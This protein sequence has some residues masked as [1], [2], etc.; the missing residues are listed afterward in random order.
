MKINKYLIII[1]LAGITLSACN[2]LDLQPLSEASTETW[3]TDRT[4]VE[5][6]LNTLYLH[7][8]WPM[9]KNDFSTVSNGVRTISNIMSLDEPTDDWMNRSSVVPFIN[10]TLSGSNSTFL[11]NT[12]SFS[13]K[14]IS[15]CNTILANIEKSK[16]N[17]SLELYERYMADARFVRACQ[18]SRLISYFGD[19]VYFTQDLELE[20]GFA[21]G[22]VDK[23]EVLGHIYEDFD[24]AIEKLPVAYESNEVKRGTK[25]AAYGMKARVALFFKDY[26]VARDAAKAC[27]DL[28]AYQLF[29]DFGELFLS[30]TKNSVETVFGIPRSTEY[31]TSLAGGAVT[32]YLSRNVTSPS[33]TASP[34]W[35]LFC[36]FLCTD[37]KPID[38]S[39]LYDRTNP[40]KNR[41]P[42]CAY[43]IVE[44]NS[45][46]FGFNYTPHPDSA[47]CWSYTENKLV[48][49]KDSKAGDT[50][51]SYNGLILRKGIDGDWNDNLEADNDKLILRY[52]D[53]LL[54]YAEAKIEL[55]SI[56]QTVLDAMN[57]VRARAYKVN[58]T[59]SSYPKI[60]ETD[61]AKLRTILRT[62]RRMEFAFE[63]MRYN[64]ILRWKIGEIVL[65]YK[66]FGLPSSLAA[67][68]T[69]VKNKYWFFPGIPQIDENGCP[70]FTTMANISQCRI[71]SQRVFDASKHY[72]WPIPSAD[73]EV[74]PNLKQNPG[75]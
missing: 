49:N 42:R 55:N 56:D 15:R 6:S 18:Y 17:L 51:A 53:V 12:W 67:S 38:E 71:L 36:A 45:N 65:N 4:Q 21:Q 43:T 75:Y 10:G 32:A 63:A 9:F 46:Y 35:D 59:S 19:V 14:A 1:G 5:M 44:F 23:L 70:D 7:Q 8:F 50:Y 37:G 41:D 40:F 16:E 28:G 29:P 69:Y 20:E 68:K 11:R 30:K 24:Y 58:Y 64:D 27:M 39:P 22:R 73:I 72:L 60:T 52:A 61:Q 33:A 74:C 47:K 62:E 31:L 66:N 3:Y 26:A 2:D 13:Y 25:G 34:S 48:T 57:M 54:M